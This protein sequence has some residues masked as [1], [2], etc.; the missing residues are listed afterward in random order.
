L[1][2]FRLLGRLRSKYGADRDDTSRRVIKQGRGKEERRRVLLG[3]I[4][5][6]GKRSKK[7]IRTERDTLQLI[8]RGEADMRPRLM[9]ME[10]SR[11]RVI[12]KERGGK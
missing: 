8:L 6:G 5:R 4:G 7:E 1:E 11:T 9:I 10:S 3:P 2:A 12:K